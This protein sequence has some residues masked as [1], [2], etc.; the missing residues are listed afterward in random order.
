MS[1]IPG[2]GASRGKCGVIPFHGRRDEATETGKPEKKLM[3]RV[4]QAADEQ[5]PEELMKLSDENWL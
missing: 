1:C 4:G 3:E 5:S 2:S